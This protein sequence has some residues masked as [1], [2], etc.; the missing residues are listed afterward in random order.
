MQSEGQQRRYE[1]HRED[2]P[3][4][5][6]IELF[7][8]QP[9]EALV[10]DE[11]E[12]IDREKASHADVMLVPR[13]MALEAKFSMGDVAY[14]RKDNEYEGKAQHRSDVKQVGD[15]PVTA[16]DGQRD[17]KARKAIANELQQRRPPIGIERM[18][19]RLDHRLAL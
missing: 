13:S 9:D 12:Y 14:P 17:R 2:W 18:Q 16:G 19:G 4:S 1:Y 11:A 8:Q 15:C 7:D 3:P 5:R 6:A 10:D